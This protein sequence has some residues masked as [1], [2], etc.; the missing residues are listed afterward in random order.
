MQTQIS[1][2]F[3]KPTDLDLHCLLRQ[4]MSCSARE[5]LMIFVKRSSH[6]SHSR[7]MKR[8]GGLVVGAH[9]L[10]SRDSGFESS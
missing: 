6:G 2:L 4:G 9:D 3:Q 8:P 10:G 1:W 5:G 7:D